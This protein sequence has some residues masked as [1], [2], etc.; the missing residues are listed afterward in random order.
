MPD[1][2][3]PLVLFIAWL[4]VPQAW[5]DRAVARLRM[6]VITSL[7]VLVVYQFVRAILIAGA[8]PSGDVINAA[9]EPHVFVMLGAAFLAAWLYGGR[10]K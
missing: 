6:P 9:V 3:L 7:S 4:A 10:E 2:V 5:L 8:T 1:W